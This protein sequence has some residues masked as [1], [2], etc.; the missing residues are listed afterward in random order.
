MR[1]FTRSP[2]SLA[3]I[4]GAVILIPSYAAAYL[5]DKV[6]YVVPMLAASALVAASF[7]TSERVATRRVDEDVEQPDDA[8]PT[9][10]HQDALPEMASG[11]DLPESGT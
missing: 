2:L 6:V 11:P 10:L 8:A 1:L 7:E 5:T 9:D 3:L 4:K